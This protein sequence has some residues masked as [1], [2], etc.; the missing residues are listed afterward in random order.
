MTTYDDQTGAALL[1]LVDPS[2]TPGDAFG[3]AIAL[4]GNDL[5]IGAPEANAAYL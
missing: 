3:A 1:T 2:R 5:L 4:V